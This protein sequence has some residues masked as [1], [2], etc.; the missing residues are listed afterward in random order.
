MLRE[1]TLDNVDLLRMVSFINIFYT[2]TCYASL[3]NHDIVDSKY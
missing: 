1:K 3:H 2:W